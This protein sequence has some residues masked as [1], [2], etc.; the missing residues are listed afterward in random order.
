MPVRVLWVVKGLGPGGAERLLAAAAAHH[1][2][3]RYDI[4]CAY[5]LP[6]KD[7]LVGDL[8]A[9]GVTTTCVSRTRSDRRWPQ[10]LWRL[11]RSGEYDAVHVHSPL[12][13]SVARIATRTLAAS[14]RP[15][16]VTT[17]HNRWQ[18]HRLPTRLLN[19]AT[20]RWDDV[21]VAV[22]DEVQASMRGPARRR[23]VT[24][25]H[26]I[27]VGGTRAAL[28]DR[29]QV[30]RDLGLTPDEIVVGTVANFRPQKDYP[31]LLGAARLLTDR[32]LAVRF[33]AVG[34]G[35]DEA[36]VH[37][38]RS[39]LGLADRVILTGF[40]P[41]AVRV[42]AACDVF[43]LASRWE[44]LPVALMEALALGLP[45]V[46]TEVGGIAEQMRD[47]VD[48]LLVPPHDARALADAIERVVT[49]D[50]LRR[51]LGEAA[52]RRAPEFDV[53][54]AVE[55]FE[56]A[57]GMPKEMTT[58]PA[59]ARRARPVDVEVR[60][61][62]P[63]DRDEI[64]GLLGR[65]LGADADD[66]RYK[67]LFAWKHDLN[68]FGPSPTWVATE[69]GA[70]IAVRAFMRWEF[71]R[72]GEILRAVRAV[73]TATDP[74]HQGKGLFR[75]LTMHGIDVLRN[76][77]A[78]FV[79]NTPND[80]SRPGYLKMG[81][82]EVGRLPAAVRFTGPSGARRAARSRVPADRWSLD[83]DVGTSVQTWLE[84]VGSPNRRVGSSDDVRRIHTHLTDDY[85]AWR[86]GTPL[87][88]YRVVD[89][90][91][92]AIIVRA[93]RRGPATELALVAEFGEPRR[94]MATAA[95]VARQVG[96]DYV[97]RIGQP[98]M[99]SGSVALPGGGPILTWRDV[100]TSGLP[101]LANWSLSL[102][103]VEL[104]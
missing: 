90:G 102:G 35:P 31:N 13:G 59:H 100:A 37:E 85:L 5:V 43:T 94:T 51:R 45:V 75:L 12:P 38:R 34:Q 40:R 73:D 20:S 8:E 77:G 84:A 87:L 97:I 60:E 80:Q 76:E 26:G 103:D 22:T 68:P 47:D 55:F 11:V 7:H 101:P 64:L 24:V 30:R 49:D 71:E 92:A 79:F 27:D 62:T 9:A 53:Q 82:R 17:E 39:E 32:N 56:S 4:E 1:D 93:R 48:A 88:K 91:E 54:H 98:Q 65:S 96:A 52:T 86:F 16:L 67:E 21:S 78:D 58:E 57:Y 46:A 63:D 95:R 104:F 18:T 74:G 99:S 70:I 89:D 19:R 61:A 25:R 72:G 42:M 66:P 10:R 2:S 81:W 69:H 36:A 50:D 23:A 29:E 6:W 15:R 41:D 83:L 3:G 28:A 14:E 33:V 44:G